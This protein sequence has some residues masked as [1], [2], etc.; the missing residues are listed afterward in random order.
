MARILA[1]SSQTI[2]GPVGNSAAVPALQEHGH[3]V[4]ALPTT[5]LSNHPGLSRP[6]GRATDVQVMQDI[7]SR[8]DDMGALD[9]CDAVTTG[10]FASREQVG[11]AAKTIARMKKG[12]AKLAV[13]V[14]PVIGDNNA[15]YVPEPIAIAIR[16]DLLPLATIATPNRFEMGWLT[17]SDTQTETA[18]LEVAHKLGVSEIIVTSAM[19]T[20][21]SISTL[22]IAHDTVYHHAMSHLDKVPNG[23]GDFLAGQYLANRMRLSAEDAFHASM[24]RLEQAVTASAGQKTLQLAR[25]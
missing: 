18:L 5:L 21:E 12:N 13:L 25:P 9:S 8:L 22:L 10:Y 14:D 1:I 15:L 19:V 4:L 20:T 7:L 24:Q 2:F 23:T 16:D 11:L 6:A 3:E 17:T